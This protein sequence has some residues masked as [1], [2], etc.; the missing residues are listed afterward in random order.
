M[1]QPRGAIEVLER[2]KADCEEWDTLLGGLERNRGKR[3][4]VRGQMVRTGVKLGDLYARPDIMETEHSEEC[5]VGAVTLLLKE[6]QRREQERVT[7]AEAGEWMSE[8]EI[9]GALEGE[10]GFLSF[11]FLSFPFLSFLPSRR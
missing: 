11:P 7:D 5:L 10:F 1:K 8:E 2:V 4:R 6:Q 9:G 3:S